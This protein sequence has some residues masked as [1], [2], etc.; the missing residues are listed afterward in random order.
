M[1]S[2]ISCFPKPIDQ[3]IHAQVIFQSKVRH[4]RLINLMYLKIWKK[5]KSKHGNYYQLKSTLAKKY[6]KTPMIGLLL[7]ILLSYT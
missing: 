6:R 2:S 7:S 5:L 1:Y 4:I 3:Y